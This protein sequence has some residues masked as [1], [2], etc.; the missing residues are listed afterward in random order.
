MSCC[1]YLCSKGVL[2]LL[3]KLLISFTRSVGHAWLA[4]QSNRWMNEV[5]KRLPKGELTPRWCWKVQSK[6]HS[7]GPRSSERVFSLNYSKLSR[8]LSLTYFFCNQA[9]ACFCGNE[10]MLPIKRSSKCTTP[11]AGNSLLMCG[12]SWTIDVYRRSDRWVRYRIIT[13]QSR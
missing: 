3:V 9:S 12:G 7:S 2:C 1:L 6:H 10:I 13:Q 8:Y 11:C 4:K 5:N